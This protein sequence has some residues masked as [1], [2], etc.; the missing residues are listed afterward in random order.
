MEDTATLS[1]GFFFDKSLQ[2]KD[3]HL[4]KDNIVAIKLNRTLNYMTNQDLSNFFYSLIHM[5]LIYSLVDIKAHYLQLA[6]VNQTH[7][8]IYL[9][10]I[11]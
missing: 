3:S 5:T 1:G 4:S 6:I 9:F 2:I 7:I 11:C 10:I 8:N